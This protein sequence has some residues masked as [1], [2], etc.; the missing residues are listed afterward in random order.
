MI[1]FSQLVLGLDWSIGDNVGSGVILGFTF[2]Q[3]QQPHNP[4]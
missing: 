1:H 2:A 4:K 3:I